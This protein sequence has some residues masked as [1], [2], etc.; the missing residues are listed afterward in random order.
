LPLVKNL[1]LLLLLLLLADGAS[2]KGNQHRIPPSP[3]TTRHGGYRANTLLESS[4]VMHMVEAN[5]NTHLVQQPANVKTHG[6]SSKYC[7]RLFLLL[8]LLQVGDVLFFH[9]FKVVS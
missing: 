1:L 4:Q 7:L 6:I 8:L 9:L 2:Y 3:K 5:N